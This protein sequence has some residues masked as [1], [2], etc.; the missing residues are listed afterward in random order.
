MQVPIIRPP[1][2]CERSIALDVDRRTANIS[3][4]Q[5]TIIQ[6]KFTSGQGNTMNLHPIDGGI[7]LVYLLAMLIIVLS[8]NAAPPRT[9]TPISS[10]I[11]KCHGGFWE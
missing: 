7:V 6:S 3:K 4:F 11:G 1:Q 2:G 5:T 8:L 9:S 10:A